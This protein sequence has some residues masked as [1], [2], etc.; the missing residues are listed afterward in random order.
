[1]ELS[2]HTDRPP[3]VAVA[4]LTAVLVDGRLQIYSR[5]GLS[6]IQPMI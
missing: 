1:M 3:T 6:A 4:E 2:L 5:I